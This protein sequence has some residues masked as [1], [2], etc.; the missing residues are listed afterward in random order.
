MS[1]N[2]EGEREK[3][4]GYCDNKRGDHADNLASDPKVSWR[5]RP[6]STSTIH[7]W[8]VPPRV[9]ENTICR[10]SGAHDGSSFR[11][12]FVTNFTD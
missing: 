12:S 4:G 7:N 5:E 11:P 3:D 9:D 1:G 8:R 6:V 10:E 2:S